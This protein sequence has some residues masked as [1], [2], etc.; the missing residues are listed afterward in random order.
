M[1]KTIYNNLVE[2]YETERAD[3]IA[4]LSNITSR[5]RSDMG[6][7]MYEPGFLEK[8]G[9]K[10]IEPYVKAQELLLQLMREEMQDTQLADVQNLESEVHDYE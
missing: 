10:M 9:V 7:Y 6:A 5:C 2:S 1:N 3:A 4:M 8:P